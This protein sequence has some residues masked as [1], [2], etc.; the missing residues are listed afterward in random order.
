MPREWLACAKSY[1]GGD[2]RA[3]GAQLDGLDGRPGLYIVDSLRQQ[4]VLLA[5]CSGPAQK[6][7]GARRLGNAG[8][9]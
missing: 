2:G 6:Q 5:G 3:Y 7:R 8:V 4:S 9:M 1:R